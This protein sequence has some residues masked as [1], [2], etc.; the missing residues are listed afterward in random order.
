[1][2]TRY[3]GLTLRNPLVIAAS[4][5]TSTAAGVRKAAEAGVGAVVLKSLFEE[6]LRADIQAVGMATAEAHPEADAYLS[7]MGMHAGAGEYLRLI[8]EAKDASTIPVIASVN[9]VGGPWWTEFA[10]QVGATGADALELNIAFL[11]TSPDETAS[12]IEDRIV[13]IVR[14]ARAASGLPVAV[15][16]GSHYTN[17]LNLASRLSSAGAGAL[18]LFNRFFRMDIDLSTLGLVAGPVHSRP[19]DYHESLRWISLLFGRVPCDLAAGTGVHDA[20]SAV[21]LVLAGAR[22]VQVCSVVYQKGFKV[23]REILDGMETWLDRR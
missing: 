19:D 2:K 5:L 10:E 6:Q 16:L 8:Q 17:L 23:V 14:T 4:S 9:C 13:Q 12:S 20:E 22:A 3:L 18:V 21:R 7:E 11:S 1:M 15:K